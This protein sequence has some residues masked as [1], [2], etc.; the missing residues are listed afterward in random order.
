[1][2]NNMRTHNEIASR[3]VS[4]TEQQKCSI[5][6][7][8]EDTNSLEYCKGDGDNSSDPITVQGAVQ[9]HPE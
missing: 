1:M 9:H 2:D 6:P 7:K 5:G 3:R 4:Q 8:P